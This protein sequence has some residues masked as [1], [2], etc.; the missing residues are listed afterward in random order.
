MVDENACKSFVKHQEFLAMKAQN[1]AYERN[2]LP[3]I[4]WNN[5]D[6]VSTQ[7]KIVIEATQFTGQWRKTNASS[8]CSTLRSVCSTNTGTLRQ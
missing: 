4:D 5:E 8:S 1:K 3:N 7:V 2:T 6:H